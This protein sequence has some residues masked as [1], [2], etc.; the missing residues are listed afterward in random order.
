LRV[1]YH[2]Y[3]LLK[4][5]KKKGRNIFERL[6]FFK[7][8]HPGHK[9]KNSF[10]S[11]HPILQKT[12]LF[13][14]SL[15]I[16]TT[17]VIL[18]WIST[19]N[20]PD[21]NDFENR[22]VQK[23]T[24]L[25]D[26]T[27]K[28]LL[29]DIHKE[30]KRTVI[31]FDE[32]GE[33]IK[34]AT[35]AI[36]DDRFYSHIGIRPLSIMRAVY[37]NAISDT[38]QGGSTITQQIVKN[39]LLSS[40]KTITRKIKEWI[41]AV[42]IERVLTKDEILAIYLNESPYGGTVYGV[43]QASQTYFSKPAKELTIAEAAYIASIPQRP[44]YFL[45]FGKNNDKLLIRKDYG[46]LRMKNLGMITEE[47]YTQAKNEVIKLSPSDSRNIKAPHFVFY[48]QDYLSETFGEDRVNQ[49]GLKVI[50]TIDYDLQQKAEE[51]V[52]ENALANKNNFNAE[53]M[54]MVGIDP[55]TSQILFMVGSRD[56]FDKTIEGAYNIATANR[57]PGSSFKPF[58]YAL[59]FEKGY[60]PETIMFDVGTEFNP[61]CSPDH[62][63]MVAGA[64]CYAPQNY[65]GTFHGAVSIRKALASSL[66]IPAVQTLYMVGLNNAIKFARDL[67]LTTLTG[68][69]ERYGLS[70]V[71]GGAEVKLLEMANAYGTFANGGVYRKET[72]ILSVKDSSGEML[73]EFKQTE[74]KR[75]MKENTAY[76]VSSVLSDNDARTLVFAPNSALN[77]PGRNVAAKTG[78]TNNNKDA[79]IIGYSQSMVI[80]AWAGNND[81]RSMTDTGSTIAG[82]AWN[83]MFVHVLNTM[84]DTYPDTPF[85]Q[86]T[87]EAN[88]E[89][90]NPLVR[91]QIPGYHS[92]LYYIN[93]DD[94]QGAPPANPSADPQF[95]NWEAAIAAFFYT[96]PAPID[97]NQPVDPNQP[98]GDPDQP[99]EQ[100]PLLQQ[101]LNNI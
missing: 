42:K 22:I 5:L 65:T 1:W 55:K 63:P 14:L 79:W 99:Q 36:E 86:P 76:K 62:L 16:L 8:G 24:Q 27:G 13:I 17:T 100:Q 60:L 29:Y 37:G 7:A 19:I 6:H 4:P 89:S 57:Q 45:P 56:Y 70:L 35:I 80:G 38:T 88:Y 9:N 74:G 73:E 28:I 26:R 87:P 49:G 101:L 72:G 66:N 20:L 39:T 93:K 48:I 53:N 64:V 30:F 15:G 84:G 83:K 95:N 21:F 69:G 54:G 82:P 71:L 32:M 52:K 33:N 96:P 41:L 77:I 92:S 78:T 50:T 34:M 11:R 75:V 3:M 40:E 43:E 90:I 2:E 85:P 94:P 98:P 68:G 23:S 91:G 97:P 25:Y 10:F 46:L 59:A 18:I 58:V 47:Q 31:P 51:L 44:T 61:S 67:G 12:L 81:G